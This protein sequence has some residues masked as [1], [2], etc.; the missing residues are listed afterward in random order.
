ML[1]SG[2]DAG[3]STA[4][5]QLIFT[6][7]FSYEYDII[8]C[9]ANY[10]DL[11]KS[12]FTEIM[13]RIEQ[14]GL[15]PFIEERKKPLKITN[16][17][18]GNTIHFEGIGGADLSRS[19]GLKTRKKVSLIVVDET[20]QLPSQNNLDQALAT[21][22][23]HLDEVQWNI[24]LAFNPERQ[25]SHWCNE[26][27]RGNQL[28][29]NWLCM[30]TS[31]KDISGYLTKV[32]LE[33]IRLE[34]AI[35]PDNYRYLYLGET[36]GLFGGV[37]H[38]FNR[39]FHLIR[40]KIV[41]ELIKTI[42]IFS[43]LIG[44]DA[45]TTRDKTGFVPTIILNNGQGIVLNYFYHDPIKNGAIS[46]DIL[47]P[48]VERWLDDLHYRWSIPSNMRIDMIFDSA[49]ADLRLV[50]ARRLPSRYVCVSYSQKNIV[51]M[52]HIMQNAFGRNVLYIL[53][54]DGIHNY[55]NNRK[56][57]GFHPLVTQLESVTW[58]ETG[59]KFDPIVPNDLTDALTY[60]TAF[61]FRNPNALYF[62][63]MQDYYE[64]SE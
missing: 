13:V 7:L 40:E 12:I 14:E 8:V 17:L 20:Q 41:R 10:A 54:E 3:K 59:D 29:D 64:R 56:E 50:C 35:N 37:Y 22:R 43:V 11:Y 53:D 2:R 18:N 58:A 42:G 23:R 57:Y 47:Y 38:T 5:A 49:N 4:L 25:N 44:V 9:R 31:Y 61:Y 32:D 62:P 34:K 48:F 19:K 39:S 60:S 52:A 16:K 24:I 26:Y 6:N 15:L 1:K 45:A 33:A 46:N 21:F 30:E 36:E 28:L 51:Q 55:I 63:K 27:F